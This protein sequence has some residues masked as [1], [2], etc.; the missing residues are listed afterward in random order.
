ME[1]GECHVEAVDQAFARDFCRDMIART[2][3]LES[4]SAGRMRVVTDLRELESAMRE[5]VLAVAVH[6]EG[7]EAIDRDLEVLPEFYEA[8]LRSLGLVWSRPN[9]FGH[10]VP[11][12]FP[13]TPDTGPG[14]TDAG[15]ELIRACNRM[16]ILVDLAH[17]NERGFWDAAKVSDK[18]LVV[19]HSAV[20][21]LAATSRNLTDRQLDAI[22]ES[23]GLVGVTFCVTDIRSDGRNDKDTPVDRITAHMDYIAER[24]GIDHVAFGS[25]FDG[26][27][28]PNEIGDVTGLPKVIA[29]L[30]VRGYDTAA[31]RKVAFENWLRVLGSCWLS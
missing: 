23:G 31:L 12:V 6:F 16:G 13:S 1:A 9:V 20:H 28:I 2:R 21:A 7:A 17:L 25:D 24:I 30:R 4:Q 15:K 29:A 19:S 11:F 3:E 27:T 18:P 22:G 5:A 26:A 8:G 10:G 14:L